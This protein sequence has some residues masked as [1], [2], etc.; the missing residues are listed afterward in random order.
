MEQ[1]GLMRPGDDQVPGTPCGAGDWVMDGLL[2]DLLPEVEA[3]SGV[4]LFPTY[5]YFRVYKPGDILKIHKDRPACE[6]SVTLCLGYSA[7][8]PWPIWIA[9]PNGRVKVSLEPGDALL[10]RGIEC[11][12][13]RE[14]FEGAHQAQ[15]FLHYVDQN[16]PCADWK[17]DKRPGLA[18]SSK[19][20][21][22][23]I[24]G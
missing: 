22:T 6:I 24:A 12:H 1:R 14:P 15:V 19:P 2:S 16:G 21:A 5:A 17:Y 18:I 10:Y 7:P 9:G 20:W 11:T 13:W 8:A 4:H 23:P 3:A